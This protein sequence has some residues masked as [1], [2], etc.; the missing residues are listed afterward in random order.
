MGLEDGV[1]RWGLGMDLDF[2]CA[3]KH[4]LDKFPTLS[5]SLDQILDHVLRDIGCFE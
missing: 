5:S 1:G 4:G 2:W 3:G